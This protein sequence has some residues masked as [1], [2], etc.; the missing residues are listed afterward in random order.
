MEST[1][2]IQ[3]Q[4][5]LRLIYLWAFAEAGLG[6]LLHLY[7]IP[8]TGLIVGGFSIII[9]V[10]LAKYSA[11]NYKVL[12]QATLLVLS[13]KFMMSPQTPLGGYI[14]VAFQ[15]L[16]A[17]FIFP[18]FKV[19]RLSI[20]IYSIIVMLESSLQKFLMV[21]VIFGKDFFETILSIISETFRIEKSSIDDVLMS[22]FLLYIG[23]YIVWAIGIGL[24]T[25]QLLSSV[26]GM[27]INKNLIRK[28]IDSI[29]DKKTIQSTRKKRR[30]LLIFSVFCFLILI[31]LYVTKRA[32]LWQFLRLLLVIVFFY[33]LNKFVIK[34]QISRY[35]K[36]NNSVITDIIYSLPGLT[37]YSKVAWKLASDHSGIKRIK[38]FVTYVIWLT[39]FYEK[40][41]NRKIL[42]LNGDIQTGKSSAL[43]NWIKNKNAGGIITPTV[44]GKKQLYN[45]LTNE[46]QPYELDFAAENSLVVGNYFLD[47]KAFTETKKIVADSIKQEKEW[48]IIDEI[49]KLELDNKGNHET[50][51]YLLD[52]FNE[53]LFLVVRTSLVDKVIGK[54]KL[55]NFTI[56]SKE[57]L[58]N[59][60]E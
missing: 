43:M 41:Q 3:T 36:K 4:T 13:V 46:Y 52:N 32:E 31:V 40:D 18:V 49:G 11:G 59:Q 54:Y 7:H 56:I 55:E 23:L 22:F 26:S 50:V 30:Y 58:I 5:T 51:Q 48:I 17:A 42:I 60:N 47:K 9:N 57:E 33:I 2:G 27:K 15:G 24:W 29:E 12:L 44:N 6:G 20:I 34:K 1:T 53:N 28:T 37:L 10:F 45:I 39:I 35:T 19:N 21:A 16:L 8:L 14:A 25:K 38:E